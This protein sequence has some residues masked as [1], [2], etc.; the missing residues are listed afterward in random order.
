MYSENNAGGDALL[1][2]PGNV[3]SRLLFWGAVSLESSHRR[4]LLVFLMLAVII[5]GVRGWPGKMQGQPRELIGVDLQPMMKE[6]Q[7]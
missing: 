5:G 3:G 4:A 7:H 6:L 1:L 2:L